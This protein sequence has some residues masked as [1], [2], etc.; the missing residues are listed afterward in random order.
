MSGRDTILRDLVEWLARSSVNLEVSVRS[1]GTD[2]RA[3]LCRDLIE[4]GLNEPGMAVSGYGDC[5]AALIPIGEGARRGD[6]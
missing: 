5:V 6:G 4:A 1:R 2:G 3:G